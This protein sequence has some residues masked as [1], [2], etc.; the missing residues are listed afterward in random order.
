MV[1]NGQDERLVE[2]A[3]G[4]RRGR[5]TRRE[6][7]GRGLAM[8]FSL[9]FMGT[10]LAACSNGSKPA[11][12]APSGSGKQAQITFM[13]PP[14]HA[15]DQKFQEEI[16]AAFMAANPTIKVSY[17]TYNWA[18]MDAELAT[19]YAGNSPPDVAYLVDMA[20]PKY[21]QAG[22]L[23]D[24]SEFIKDPKFANDKAAYEEF[25]WKLGQF[26]GKQIGIPTL[27]ALYLIFYNKDL[28]AKAGI[29]SFP[30]TPE[31]FL[32]AAQKLNKPGQTWGVSI[33]QSLKDYA[34]WDWFPSL[35]NAGTDV[36]T[37]DMKAPALNTPDAA[38]G[39][40]FLADLQ[41]KHKVAPPVGQYDWAGMQDLFKGGKVAIQFGETPQ[42]LDLQ[43]KDPGFKWDI[44]FAPKGPKGQSVIGNF[45]F[46]AVSAKSKN[47]EAAWQFIKFWQSAQNVKQYAEKV[48]LQICRKD[49]ADLYKGND[50]LVKVQ[51]E[52]VPKVVGIQAHAKTREILSGFWPEMEG[53]Y[54]GQKTAAEALANAE[55]IVKGLLA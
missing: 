21:A 27:G 2:L 47:K 18:T 43:A 8:G 40:Q 20:Y 17:A 50:M 29:S 28:F 52:F 45:G 42:I 44:A 48:T 11:G 25:P 30:D 36:L 9:S 3:D 15:D 24:L 34:F 37:P 31:A 33:R 26:G 32:E 13:K 38:K 53:A 7:I 5:L 22:A 39:T 54:S 10:F 49:I 6:L 16:I 19:A 23:A 35:H 4:F 41:F 12:G 14:H 55:K 46:L 51:K 1:R